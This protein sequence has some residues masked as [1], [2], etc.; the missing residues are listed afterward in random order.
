[1]LNL[2]D[3][4]DVKA[5]LKITASTLYRIKRKKI[6]TAIGIGKHDYYNLTEIQNLVKYY[7]K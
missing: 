2:I 5:I 7:L 3:N 4:T 6:I 1:M